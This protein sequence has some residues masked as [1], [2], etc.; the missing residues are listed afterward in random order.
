RQYKIANESYERETT[1]TTYR[2]KKY[3]YIVRSKSYVQRP[4]RDNVDEDDNTIIPW[5][6][7]T[8][9]SSNICVIEINQE[10]NFPNSLQLNIYYCYEKHKYYPSQRNTIKMGNAYFCKNICLQT[11]KRFNKRKR[12]PK[13]LLETW[14]LKTFA[15][16][17]I[18]TKSQQIENAEIFGKQYSSWH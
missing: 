16:V 10:Q 14:I 18:E 3:E 11:I 2:S 9:L 15:D 17:I 6:C 8:F 13:R 4:Y 12:E 1:M 7:V 5:R